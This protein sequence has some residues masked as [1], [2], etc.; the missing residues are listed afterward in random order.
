LGV[1]PY[2]RTERL[3]VESS[4]HIWVVG[5]RSAILRTRQTATHP[6]LAGLRRSGQT[7]LRKGH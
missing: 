3:P 5:G 1:V 6:V 4:G 2:A 7:R